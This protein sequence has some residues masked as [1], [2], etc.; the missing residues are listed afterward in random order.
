MIDSLRRY[1]RRLNGSTIEYDVTAYSPAL[2]RIRAALAGLAL[3]GDESLEVQL[4]ALRHQAQQGVER[5]ELVEKCFALVTHAV[6]RTLGIKPFDV[7]LLGALAMQQGRIAEIQTG[8]GKTLTAVFVAVLEALAGKGVHVLTF[9]DY[10]ARRDAAWMGPV[11]ALLGL[12]VAWVGQGMSGEERRQ[13]YAAD[14]TYVTAKECGFDYLR[15]LLVLQRSARVQR[16]FAV[17]IVDEADSI[18]IDEARIPLVLAATTQDHAPGH[19]RIAALVATM[20]PGVEFA[21]DEYQRVVYL[22]EAGVESVEQALGCGNLYDA[23]NIETLGRI[24]YALHA[25]FLLVRDKDYLVRAGAIQLLDECTGRAALGRR[26]PD[27]LQAA[28]EAKEGCAVKQQGSLLNTLTLQHLLGCYPRVCGMTAT[29]QSAEEELRTFYGLSITVIAPHRP[30]IRCDL[31]DWVVG[32]REEKQQL[33][34]EEIQ[35]IHASGQPILVGTASVGES[36][37]L[38]GALGERGVR[39]AVLNAR[40]DEQEAAIIA[41]AGRLGAVTISTN[42]A[43]RGTDIKLGGADEAQREEVMALGGLFVLGTTRYESRGIDNQLRGRAGRQG[44]PGCSRFIICLEDDLFVRYKLNELLSPRVKAM[45]YA[46]SDTLRVDA[47]SVGREIDRVQRIVEGQN[48]EIK[49]TLYKY[50]VLLERQRRIVAQLR[51]EVLDEGWVYE[52]IALERPH[53][54]DALVNQIGR[55]RLTG[56]VG[57][58]MVGTID[59]KWSRYLAEINEVRDTI[60]LRRMGGEEPLLVFHRL[61]V[62]AFELLLEDIEQS[63]ET[64]VQGLACVGGEL[65]MG[66]ER[67]VVPTAT[68]TYLINDDPMEHAF[69]LQLVANAGLNV[70]AA[71]AWPLTALF[72]LQ[73]RFQRRTRS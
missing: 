46:K 64:L 53:H 72:L 45:V 18:L 71:F 24:N 63:I 28:V 36:E 2:Q 60:H 37:A 62:G 16:P 54:I 17:A 21:H 10:L 49:Q 31:P 39:C 67:V 13:A 38:A 11:Y 5:E 7:Q 30:C 59:T 56:Q 65:R 44:E 73:H 58:A 20:R 47:V 70:A 66:G 32:S 52:R 27:G 41:Q 23:H 8:E 42:M 14:I 3:Q 29:A 55:E 69:G 25:R 22:T 50:S 19:G 48:L 43:G 34:I 35:R 40:N 68:W 9:N 4:R 12:R 15:D 26:W 6:Q 57:A 33:V 61:I 1:R 51:E